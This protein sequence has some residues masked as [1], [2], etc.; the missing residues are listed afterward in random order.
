MTDMI[1]YANFLLGATSVVFASGLHLGGGVLGFCII[2]DP[3]PSLLVVNDCAVIFWNYFF[4]NLIECFPFRYRDF[5]FFIPGFNIQNFP[6]LSMKGSITC[7]PGFEEYMF[8][9]TSLQERLQITLD[10]G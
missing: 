2:T 6:I 4:T 9:R 7:L 5:M 10:A 1:C 3:P 8:S